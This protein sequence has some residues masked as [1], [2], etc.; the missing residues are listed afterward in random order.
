MEVQNEGLQMKKGVL[1]VRVSCDL[2]RESKVEVSIVLELKTP[3]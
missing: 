1:K 3:I 2:I